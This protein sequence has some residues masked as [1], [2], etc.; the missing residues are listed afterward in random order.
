MSVVLQVLSQASSQDSALLK[1]AEEQLRHWEDQPG[2]YS[3]LQVYT[4]THTQTSGV[5]YYRYIH[6]GAT[7]PSL[8]LTQNPPLLHSSCESCV[9]FAVFPSRQWGVTAAS[10]SRRNLRN[11]PRR[12]VTAGWFVSSEAPRKASTYILNPHMNT[13]KLHGG[14]RSLL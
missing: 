5:L 9:C 10:W 7:P 6:T 1:P 2:F 14:I 4:H 13:D 11:S 12:M 8:R 3:I